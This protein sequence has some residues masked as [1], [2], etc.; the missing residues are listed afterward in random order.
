MYLEKTSQ[1]LPAIKTPEEKDDSP[2]SINVLTLDVNGNFVVAFYDFEDQEW[3]N[4]HTVEPIQGGVTHFGI[5]P[6]VPWNHP[7]KQEETSAA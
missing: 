4:A 2:R 6:D 3:Y 1:L 5:L 7:V